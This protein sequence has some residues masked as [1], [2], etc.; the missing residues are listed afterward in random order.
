[1]YL[2][3]YDIDK[4]IE[5]HDWKEVTSS[6]YFIQNTNEL[7]PQGL[8]SKEI[9]GEPGTIERE[10]L[11]GYVRLNDVFM[12][13]QAY[14]VLSRL[15]QNIAEDM[16]SGSGRYY[17]DS[18]GELT[19]LPKN[20]TVPDSAKY[21]NLG[22]GFDWLKDAW[23]YISWNITKDMTKTAKV[24][25]KF[26]KT[27]PIGAIFWDK[28]P[29]MPAFYR[30][31]DYTSRKQNVIN[32]NYTK[33]IHLAQIIKT[34]DNLLFS[35]DYDTP[36]K[37]ISHVKCQDLMN[38]ISTEFLRLIG[39]ANGFIN[40]H[41]TG[42][43]QDYSAR[44]VISTSVSNQERP[45]YNDTDFYASSVPLSV[46][47]NIFAPFMIF[48]VKQWVT[49][50]ISGNRFKRIYDFDKKE[51]VQKEVAPS[52]MDEFTADGIR[53]LMDLYKKNKKF[54]VK[55]IT[56]KG[57]DGE[58]I[59]IQLGTYIDKK[60]GKIEL[61][62]LDKIVDPDDPELQYVYRN[63]TYCEFFYIIAEDCLKNKCVDICRYPVDDYYH[64][65]PSKMNIIPANKYRNV[66][67]DGIFYERYPILRYKDETEI[68]HLFIDSLRLF[69]IYPSSL[70][71]DFDG[72]QVSIQGIFSDEANAEA[73]KQ[74]NNISHFVGLDGEIMRELPL[75]V[76]HGLHCLTY[77]NKKPEVK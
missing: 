9:F 65:Y 14:Y 15:K 58:R 23:P 62:L 55:P 43:T 21:K 71:G 57:V 77:M 2:D 40:K 63:L 31:V 66:R 3:L 33:L 17:V 56:L 54:R 24:R 74:M 48:N 36:M 1:M 60:T 42:K 4:D 61:N 69:S 18:K 46:A 32:K 10:E 41:V 76:R 37:S 53:K 72:D 45:E 38:E 16:K 34:T 19:K 59:P 73:M 13:P 11:W 49:N 64:V 8:F 5:M 26:L 30:D 25:R 22:S 29:I 67:M 52:F 27:F 20:Q 70:G 50:Y 44:L 75:G 6:A 28:F 39:G 7:H 47:I 68:E 12:N 35:D 51:Y